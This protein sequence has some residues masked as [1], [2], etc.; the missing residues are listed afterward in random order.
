MKLSIITVT[1]NNLEGLRRTAESV[2][3]QVWRDFEWI[4]VD[5][6]SSDGT[7]EYL[8]QL[9]PQPDCWTSEPD[10][11]VYDAMNKGL[12]AARG[13]YLLFLNAGDSLC[14]AD[15][16][17]ECFRNFPGGDVVYGDAVFVYPKKEKRMIHPDRLSL[18][19]FRHRSLCHQATFIRTALLKDCGGYSLHYRIVSDWRQWIVWM[20][21]GRTFR[22]LSLTVCRYMMDGLSTSNRKTSN[23]EREEVFREVLP[24]LYHELMI[25]V[26]ALYQK[27]K[28]KYLRW[29]YILSAFSLSLIIT[30]ALCLL[31]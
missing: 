13:E 29:I 8:Q 15:T 12:S 26:E 1:R 24:P 21:E 11:G 23:R 28:Q 18:Y 19:Y 2:A 25:E 27:K 3:A 4:V 17:Q 14:S 10:R 9:S 30:L 7:K 22:H 20:L 31:N 5:G 16:L 6:D